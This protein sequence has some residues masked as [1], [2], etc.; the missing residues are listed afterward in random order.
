[1]KVILIVALVMT[2][3][4]EAR[5]TKGYVRKNGTYVAPYVRSKADKSVYNNYGYRPGDE[6]KKYTKRRR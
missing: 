1:M 2:A 6:V 5:V 3:L 4:A